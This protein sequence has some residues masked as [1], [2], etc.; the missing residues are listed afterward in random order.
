MA[1]KFNRSYRITVDTINANSVGPFLPGAET[2]QSVEIGPPFSIEFDLVQ[3]T[4]ASIRTLDLT[5]Y[6][7]GLAARSLLRKDMIP[8]DRPAGDLDE[9]QIEFWAGYSDSV[10]TSLQQY[11]Q[12][13]AQQKTALHHSQNFPTIFRGIVSHA[14]SYSDGNSPNAIT[15]IEA[16]DIGTSRIVGDTH[17]P[18]TAGTP[19][20]RILA[21]LISDIPRI[22]VGAIGNFDRNLKRGMTCVG[23]PVPYI[24]DLT[25]GHFFIYGQKGY[26]LNDNEYLKGPVPMINAA[27]GLVGTPRIDAT[28]VSATMLFEPG[29]VL[30][31]GVQLETET[32]Q[33]IN[34]F[35]KII[36]IH[37]RGIISPTQSGQCLTTVEMTNYATLTNSLFTL[38]SP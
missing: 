21:D 26:C 27:S 15:R 2:A 8:I 32:I 23:D 12:S 28:I 36:G 4:G 9:R 16:K 29:L 3:N 1:R 38:V 31:Q 17:R 19:V 10:P 22:S 11:Y 20:R 6:N 14:Y 13:Q 30:A 5:I 18:Y 24:L 7:L 37:H 35:Y 33:G 25:D 34:G